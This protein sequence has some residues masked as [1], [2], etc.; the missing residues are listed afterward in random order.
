MSAI[1]NLVVVSDLHCGCRM[2]LCTADIPLDGGGFYTQSVIQKASSLWWDEFW[3]DWVP[4]ATR[5][6]PFAVVVNGDAVEGTH[7]GS[8][9]PISHNHADQQRAAEIAL[10]PVVAACGGRFYMVRGTEAHVGQSSENEERLGQALGAVRNEKGAATSYSL[11][12]RVGPAL[13]HLAHHIG[14]SSKIG[15]A[16]SAITAEYEQMLANS[17]RW[18]WEPPDVIVRSHIHSNIE[19]KM[20]T[21]RQFGM[22]LITPAWQAMTP[23]GRKIRVGRVSEAQMGGILIRAEGDDV[24]SR[25]FV[26]CMEP[27]KEVEIAP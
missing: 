24:Y 25:S 12:L 6:E 7:H 3:N 27:A 15:T 17:A 4:E 5:G 26:R 18:G 13:V 8:K 19:V 1:N 16:A 11:R 14:G 20:P 21:A 2:G 9:T 23:F 10:Q 22:C